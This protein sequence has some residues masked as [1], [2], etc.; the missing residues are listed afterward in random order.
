MSQNLKKRGTTVGKN[1]RYGSSQS[2]ELRKKLSKATNLKNY[3]K[4][5]A[6]DDWVPPNTIS[7]QLSKDIWLD[8]KYEEV[9]NGVQRYIFKIR[10]NSLKDVYF[11]SDFSGS[12][13]VMIKADGDKQQSLNLGGR[14][15]ANFGQMIGGGA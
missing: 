2:P 12:E 6:E 4:D 13:N 15:Q 3:I 1:T 10:N 14:P 9:Q 7:K 11:F 5:K 8:K